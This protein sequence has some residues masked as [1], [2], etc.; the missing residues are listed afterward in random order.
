MGGCTNI[1]GELG[2]EEKKAPDVT[3]T[4]YTFAIDAFSCF[5]LDEENGSDDWAQ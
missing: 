4:I 3:S 5:N 2:A 1:L